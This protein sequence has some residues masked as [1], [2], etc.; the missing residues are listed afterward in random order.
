MSEREFALPEMH[1]PNPETPKDEKESVFERRLGERYDELLAERKDI[2]AELGK[3]KV[4]DFDVV[5]RPDVVDDEKF[6]AITNNW[7]AA[8]KSKTALLQPLDRLGIDIFVDDLTKQPGFTDHQ[9]FFGDE[10]IKRERIVNLREIGGLAYRG[11]NTVKIGEHHPNM[12]VRVSEFLWKGQLSQGVQVLIHELIH[13]YHLR[14]NSYL[15]GILTEAQAYFSGLLTVGEDFS[16]RRTAD[17]LTRPKSEGGL[18]EYDTDKVIAVMSAL[19]ELYGLGKSEDEIGDL[20]ARSKFNRKTGTYEPLHTELLETRLAEGAE[21]D[22]DSMALYDIYRLHTTN[23]R[24][25]ARLELFKTIEKHYSLVQLREMKLDRLRHIVAYPTYNIDGR[26][27]PTDDL[28][29]SVVCPIDDEFPYDF[30]GLR[31]GIIFGFFPTEGKEK[32][33]FGLGRWEAEGYDGRVDLAEDAKQRN[34]LLTSLAAAAQNIAPEHKL[35]LIYRFMCTKLLD[36]NETARQ[37]IAALNESETDRQ[38]VT[39]W[40]AESNLAVSIMMCGEVS[41]MIRRGYLNDLDKEKVKHYSLQLQTL[42]T[43]RTLLDLRFDEKHTDF[44]SNVDYLKAALPKLIE[45]AG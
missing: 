7:I 21:S 10:E 8:I 6:T 44:I 32:Q 3:Y 25:K 1:Q 17:V 14:Q 15:D 34:Q 31:T 9:I 45:S 30:D 24:L 41:R 26:P 2:L 4:R 18:Y 23:Q 36:D 16:L 29:Q 37:I 27:V 43:V 38:S 12:R 39:D 42:E 35:E 22:E 40:L 33:K 11:S 28:M 20:L 13:R 19:A 5:T